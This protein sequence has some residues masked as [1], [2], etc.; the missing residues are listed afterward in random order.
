MSQAPSL[1]VVQSALEIANDYTALEPIDLIGDGSVA[2]RL[3]G[4]RL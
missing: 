4:S 2:S 3:L 1:L